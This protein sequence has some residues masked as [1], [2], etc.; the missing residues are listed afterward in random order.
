MIY[1]QIKF[2]RKYY[3]VE[4]ERVYMLLEKQWNADSEKAG[5]WLNDE[6]SEKRK[7][8]E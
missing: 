2:P 3:F 6:S 4:G 7:G 8:N 1:L 5:A